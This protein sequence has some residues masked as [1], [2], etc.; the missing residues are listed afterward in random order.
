MSYF[1]NG[2]IKIEKEFVN[3]IEITSKEYDIDGNV[4]SVS[5]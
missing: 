1:P 5:P 4:I 2:N 3:N